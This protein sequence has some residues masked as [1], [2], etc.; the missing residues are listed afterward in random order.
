MKWEI[1]LLESLKSSEPNSIVGDPFGS[2]LTQKDYVDWGIPVIRGVNLS[3]ESYF[4]DEDFVY[5]SEQ[6]A[7]KLQQNCAYPGDLIFTQ[8][9]TLGQVGLIPHETK[10]PKYL[11]SQSQ[12]KVKVDSTRVDAKFLYYYFRSPSVIQLIKNLAITSGVP[13]INLGIL[14]KFPVHIPALEVQRQIASVLSSYDDLIENNRRR[15]ELLEQ[16]ARL[17]YK[18]WFVHFRFPGHEHVKIVDGV[19]EGWKNSNVPDVIEINPRES[20]QKGNSIRY[21]PMS[22]LSETGMTINTEE[23][24]IR[25]NQTN[26]RFRNGDVLLARIT[27]CLENG[28]TAFVNVLEKDE[29]AC[30]STEFIVMRGRQVSSYFTYCFARTEELRGHAINSMIGSSGRQRVQV[31]AFRDYQVTIPPREL[32]ELFDEFASPCFKQIEILQRENTHLKKAR[33]LLLPRLMNGEIAI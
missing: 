2:D 27:P 5:V 33:D 12:M 22:S 15:I 19:P 17:L 32:L 13:H 28:K 8:R 10:F 25:E 18:E 14:K 24:E 16:A 21:I 30:G 6:K 7:E 11:V 29:V 9:G 23:V 31:S 3:Q 4:N 26:V 20:T 1:A